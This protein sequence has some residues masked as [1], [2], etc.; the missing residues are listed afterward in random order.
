[1]TSTP[2]IVPLSQARTNPTTPAARSSP[3]EAAANASSG[4]S[5][6]GTDLT[7]LGAHITVV[8]KNKLQVDGDVRGDVHGKHVLITEEGSVIG[9]VH[10]ETIEVRGGVRG[11]I[12]AQS[13][14][15]QASAQVYGDITHNRLFIADGAEFDGGVHRVAD[16]NELMPEL[17]PDAIERARHDANRSPFLTPPSTYPGE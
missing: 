17:D 6:I 4:T 14:K 2:S 7:I 5:V 8:S 13:V 1:M 15:L 11:A 3:F 16:A 10:A 12:R 9:T